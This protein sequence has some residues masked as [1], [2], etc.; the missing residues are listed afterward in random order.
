MDWAFEYAESN[1]MMT[2]EDYPYKGVNGQCQVSDGKGVFEVA[3]YVDVPPDAEAQLRAALAQGPVSVAIEADRWQFQFY[4]GGVFTGD[5]GTNLDHGVL[6][7]GYGSENGKDYWLVKNSWGSGWGDQG[8]IK[9][10]RNSGIV[11]GQ[12]GILQADS[13][14]QL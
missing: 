11:H 1:A 12:C 4:S 10:W 2:E 5:C 6:A 13:Y 9:I 14:P 8:Y 3:S 7:V